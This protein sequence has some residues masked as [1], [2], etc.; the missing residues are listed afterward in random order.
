M[1]GP[2]S[3]AVG[4]EFLARA[5]GMIVDMDGV[6]WLGDTPLPGL[7]GFFSALAARGIAFVLATNNSSS[8]P[9]SY[10]RKLERF[11]VEAGTDRVLTSAQAT[12]AFLRERFPRGGRVFLIGGEGLSRALEAAGFSLSEEEAEIVVVGWDRSLTWEKLARASIL[13]HRGA[14][15]VGANP[16]LSYPTPEGPV[17]GCGAQLKALEAATGVPPLVVGKPEPA[18]YREALRRLGTAPGET[19]MLGDRLDT[20]IAGA[21]RLGMASVLVLTGVTGRGDLD[22]GAV[23]PDAV[24]PD[25]A[26]LAEALEALPRRAGKG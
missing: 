8:T 2:E 1:T 26:S 19:V 23:K 20:D 12:A 22:G 16:D 11:G 7:R 24:F 25:I 21:A 10:V 5:R 15:F 13:I 9:E 14:F 4:A 6:L 17:P 18:I 3:G